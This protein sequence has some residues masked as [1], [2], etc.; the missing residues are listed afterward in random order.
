LIRFKA[1]A[2]AGAFTIFIYGKENAM[3]QMNF[4]PQTL[5]EQLKQ[6]IVGQDE[7][8]KSISNVAFLHSLRYQH[9]M[10]AGNLIERPKQNLLVIGGSGTGKTLA[11][12][13]LGSLLSLPVIIE[14]ASMLTGEGWRGRSVSNI[15]AMVNSSTDRIEDKMF[16]VIV[17]DEF[18]K[19]CRSNRDDY[20][21]VASSGFLP[22]NNLLTFMAGGGITDKD[23]NTFMDTSN[24]LIVCLGAFE[25]LDKII[26]KRLT[27]ARQI[28]F[29][30]SGHAEPD[31]DDVMQ[32]VT[33]DD[34]LEYGIPA[35]LLGR[36]SLVTRTRSLNTADYKRILTQS[37]ASPIRQYNNLLS[38]TFGVRVSITDAAVAHIAA[39]AGESKEG[40]RMLARLVSETLQPAIFSIGKDSD[41][42]GI[43]IDCKDNRLFTCS[44]YDVNLDWR[45]QY[46]DN[47]FDDIDAGCLS[48]VPLPCTSN[49]GDIL[50]FAEKV[51]KS[52]K[53]SWMMP[54]SYISAATCV[55]V[56][57]ICS[58][59]LYAGGEDKNLLT[60]Y[61]QIDSLTPEQIP[62]P[63]GFLEQ[64]INEF[65]Q[66]AQKD[67]GFEKAKTNAKHFI[68][69]YCRDYSISG[70]QFS[71]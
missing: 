62:H 26:K 57:A 51:K 70:R 30:V 5:F 35:E 15:C 65:I 60:L 36:L 45:D 67:I 11:M 4:T 56:A 27:G 16:S 13:T 58:Q 24:F 54:E 39:K 46:D 53:L 14:D 64:M 31:V 61:R 7:Y 28:G 55:V 59:I 38:K 48:T 32:Y 2:P 10:D 3:D 52:S 37:D 1:P 47:P 71:A 50:L 19:I 44:V 63:S 49:R 18:D 17:F 43:E 23:S 21:G 8:L 20:S 66:K 41:L 40:A 9:F 29:G 68:V 42:S 69:D 6:T 25:G 22:L 33:E 12:Q 34:L